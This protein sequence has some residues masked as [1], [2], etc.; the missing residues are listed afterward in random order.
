[1]RDGLALVGATP[2]TRPEPEQRART[3]AAIAP[4]GPL[5]V[6][7]GVVVVVCRTVLVCEASSGA[8]TSP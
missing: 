4:T 3:A 5:V 7:V 8:C 6:G 1:M 2:A